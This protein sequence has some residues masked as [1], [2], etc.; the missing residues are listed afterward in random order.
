[1]SETHSDPSEHDGPVV[2]PP[3]P[4]LRWVGVLTW[5]AGPARRQVRIQV[6]ELILGRDESCGAILAD[7]SVSHRHARITRNGDEFILEDLD[8]RNGTHI[9]GVP[10]LSCVLH[11]GDMIQFGQNLF[12][13]VRIL[14]GVAPAPGGP[15]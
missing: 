2:V 15:S 1:M 7:D 8:S 6:D 11:D 3:R 5:A 12:S 13:F 9:D 10:V 14:E 4:Q